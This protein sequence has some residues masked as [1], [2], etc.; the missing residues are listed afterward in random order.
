[1]GEVQN[2]LKKV[3]PLS[4]KKIDHPNRCSFGGPRSILID[5]TKGKMRVRSAGAPRFRTPLVSR[6]AARNPTAEAD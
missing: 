6:E 4:Q 2:G 3:T 5:K 1:M